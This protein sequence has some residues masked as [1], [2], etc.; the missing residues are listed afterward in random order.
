MPSDFLLSYVSFDDENRPF[1][2]AEKNGEIER[3]LVLGQNLNLEFDLS[4]KFCNGWVDF[5]KRCSMPCPDSAEVEA[6]WE[7]CLHC[8]NRTGFNPAFY[9]ASSVSEQQEKINH[10]PHFVYLAYFGPGVAKVG[11][12]QEARGLKRILE[13]GARLAIKLETFPS[14]M[15]ARQYEE[16]ISRGCNLAENITGNKKLE[17]LKTPLEPKA[18]LDEINDLRQQAEK[19]LGVA[20]ENAELI[21]A[22]KFYLHQPS[23]D[24]SSAVNLTDT[25]KVAGQVVASVGPIIITDYQNNLLAYNLKRFVGYRAKKATEPIEIE[26]PSEQM[27]LF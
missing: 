26:L 5:E 2:D 22:D 27:T 15:V 24:V 9:H 18:A 23:L 6:K 25:P 11:I 13:Q 17:L 8:R 7:N 1:V 20:F 3:L 19:T 14:A 16:R 4:Q 21:E 12:S 10:Q